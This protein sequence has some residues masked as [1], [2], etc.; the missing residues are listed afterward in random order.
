[1]FLSAGFCEFLMGK[2]EPLVGK[3]YAPVI[4]CVSGA[5]RVPRPK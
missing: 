4:S 1:L 5:R 3:R 2:L